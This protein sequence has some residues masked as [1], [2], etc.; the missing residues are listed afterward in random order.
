MLTTRSNHDGNNCVVIDESGTD[1]I[2]IFSSQDEKLIDVI[3][4]L[5]TK[6]KLFHT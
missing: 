1:I 4:T 6:D 2:L 5:K 3:N